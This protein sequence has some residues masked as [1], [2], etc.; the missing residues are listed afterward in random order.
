MSRLGWLFLALVPLNAWGQLYLIAGTPENDRTEQYGSGL[1]QVRDDGAVKL[2][3]R[4]TPGSQ[5]LEYVAISYDLR[6]AV[7][8][9]NDILN[10]DKAVVVVDLDRGDVIKECVRP[11]AEKLYAMVGKWL[12]D[13]PGQG[14]VLVWM[15]VGDS[16]DIPQTFGMLLDSSRSC[17][18]SFPGVTEASLGH[19][20]IHGTAGWGFDEGTY[21]AMDHGDARRPFQSGA[22]AAFDVTTIPQ[23][24]RNGVDAPWVISNNR[25]VLV[26]DTKNRDSTIH[27]TLV[28]RKRDRTWLRIPA[29]SGIL[30]QRAFGSFVVL[31]E[32]PYNRATLAQF[33][34]NTGTI[35]MTRN[36]ADE[37]SAGAAEW[38]D[39]DSEF[40][41]NIRDHFEFEDP[42]VFSGRLHVF[43]VETERLLTIET[44][45]AD[46]E[47]L[48]IENNTA[49][50]RVSDRLYSAPINE[51]G[52]GAAKLIAKDELIRDSHWAFIK[53]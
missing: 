32:A 2:V 45:Q 10:R 33:K 28:F 8:V 15:L 50:Y 43:D 30:L 38:R 51:K 34:K 12:A 9:P 21:V 1:I 29:P 22:V 6:K 26:L 36:A 4:L 31:T 19:I 7:I 52:I 42:R 44:H 47:V 25:K 46:S 35:T 23:N 49:Y 17:E 37:Q 24:L 5:G 27:N 48:L 20:S 14:P 13:I 41:P 11:A 18:D 39:H 3:K 16:P 53:H 40:G